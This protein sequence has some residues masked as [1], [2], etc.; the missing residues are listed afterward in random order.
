[1]GTFAATQKATRQFARPTAHPFAMP[2]FSVLLHHRNYRSPDVND[3][4]LE[5][6]VLPAETYEFAAT[7]SGE[8]VQFDH[9]P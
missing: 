3:Q 2:P 8:R 4:L 9:H 5:I 1:M 7:Q 6:H